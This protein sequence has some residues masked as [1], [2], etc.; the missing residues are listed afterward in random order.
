MEAWS[1]VAPVQGLPL[2]DYQ[3]VGTGSTGASPHPQPTAGPS[4][5]HPVTRHIRLK[6]V[7]VLVHQ[8]PGH[9]DLR[10]IIEVRVSV[11]GEVQDSVLRVL[12]LHPRQQW[13]GHLLIEALESRAGTWS[14]Q[15]A[16]MGRHGEDGVGVPSLMPM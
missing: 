11:L 15:A 8:A 16:R 12:H 10:A 3:P 13:V 2:L 7:H 4:P 1:L 5:A 14:P 6:V 9:H